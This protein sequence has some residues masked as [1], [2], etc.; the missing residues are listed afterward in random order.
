LAQVLEAL[1][2]YAS[3]KKLQPTGAEPKPFADALDAFTR[4][5]AFAESEEAKSKTAGAKTGNEA[6]FKFDVELRGAVRHF[7][8]NTDFTAELQREETRTDRIDLNRWLWQ[9]RCRLLANGRQFWSAP[10][11]LS[12]LSSTPR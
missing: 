1:S 5:K 10:E 11:T 4:L 2:Y 7:F 9:R 12:L 8:L 6:A 3:L